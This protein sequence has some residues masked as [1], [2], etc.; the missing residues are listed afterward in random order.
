MKKVWKSPK[1]KSGSRW[2]VAC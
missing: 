1:R 2:Y